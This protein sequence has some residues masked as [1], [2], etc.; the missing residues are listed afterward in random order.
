MVLSYF[1]LFRIVL[2]LILGKR[3]DLRGVKNKNFAIIGEPNEVDRVKQILK[4]TPHKV[5][6]IYPVSPTHKKTEKDSGVLNQLDQ[7]I[8]IY[9]IDE[10]IF[11]AKNTTAESIINWMSRTASNK[12]EFKIAQ[13]N[14]M[15]L[16]GSNSIDTAGDLYLMEIDNIS[17]PSSKRNKRTFDFI[18]AFLLLLLSPILIWFFK[19]KLQ[20]IKNCWAV[21]IGRQ[22]WVGYSFQES[23]APRN[24]PRIK[25]GILTPAEAKVE[26][27]DDSLRSKLNLIYA[28]DYSIL[29][30]ILILRKY[31]KR[32]DR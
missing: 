20:F 31:W 21:L 15:Y 25:I 6:K 10:V 17:T 14:S 11:C 26:A 9:D 12:V 1:L 19:N 24:L 16:I 8:D 22:S 23:P 30:D 28:R 3:F 27:Q 18:L 32:L 4:N 5:N 7:I 13:P 2:H 29:T